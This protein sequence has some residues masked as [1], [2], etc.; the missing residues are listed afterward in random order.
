VLYWPYTILSVS[1]A[2]LGV[3][4]GRPD[5]HGMPVNFAMPLDCATACL[6]PFRGVGID[7]VSVG[8]MRAVCYLAVV[9]MWI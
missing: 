5:T 1:A 4:K 7:F 6:L 2:F 9:N 3:E 8:E